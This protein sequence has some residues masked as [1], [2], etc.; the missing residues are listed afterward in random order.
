MNPTFAAGVVAISG[1]VFALWWAISAKPRPARAN[2]FADL[3][4]PVPRERSSTVA[5]RSLGR[6]VRSVVPNPL[7]NGLEVKLA[8]AGHPHNLDLTGSWVS[9]QL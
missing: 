2:L 8:Q 4:E 9:R 1:A 6:R 7:M 5:L 3:P